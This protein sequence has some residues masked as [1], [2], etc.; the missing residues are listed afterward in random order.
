MD[1]LR[2]PLSTSPFV[3]HRILKWLFSSEQYK[4]F[5]LCFLFSLVKQPFG[6]I[7]WVTIAMDW[8]RKRWIECSNTEFHFQWHQQ[9]ETFHHTRLLCNYNRKSTVFI[10][11]VCF[12]INRSTQVKSRYAPD[13]NI[14][15]TPR[16][17]LWTNAISLKFYRNI[18]VTTESEIIDKRHKSLL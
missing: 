5:H 9:N 16:C 6:R 12:T 15:R 14:L 13:K 7:S 3:L 2:L 10:D 17:S 1:K 11:C 8:R 4:F 18:L